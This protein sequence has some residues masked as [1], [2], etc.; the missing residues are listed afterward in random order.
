MKFIFFSYYII[1]VAGLFTGCSKTGKITQTNN[2]TPE[3]T[4]KEGTWRL[5]LDL[6]NGDILPFIFNLNQ[7]SS[8]Y[9]MVIINDTERIKV[10]SF[11]LNAGAIHI[12]MPIFNSEFK[13]VVETPTKIKGIWYNKAK[14]ED[15]KVPFI[16]NYA[17]LA[18]RFKKTLYNEADFIDYSGKWEVTFSK[19]TE[20]E[21]KAIGLFKQTNNM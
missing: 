7:K 2:T 12:S 15:Y 20:D 18:D 1:V 16:A 4:I 10:E 6:N 3:I 5:T 19:G 17:P 14:G 21:Y 13:G 9:E 11:T 8:G